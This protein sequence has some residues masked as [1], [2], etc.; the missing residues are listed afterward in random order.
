VRGHPDELRKVIVARYVE[1]DGFVADP[2]QVHGIPSLLVHGTISRGPADW[3]AVLQELTGAQVKEINSTAAATLLIPVGETVYALSYG[4]GYLLIDPQFIDP[5]FG[6]GFAVRAIDPDTIRQ[7]TRTAMLSQPR[8]ER[9]SVPAGQNIRWYGIEEYGEIVGRITGQLANVELTFNRGHKR[10][11]SVAGTDSLKVHLATNPADLLDDLQ[12]ISGVCDQESPAQELEFI[13]RL[14]A[15]KSKDPLI[16]QLNTLLD[17][18]LGGGADGELALAMPLACQNV[19]EEHQS[20]RVKIGKGR[21]ATEEDISLDTI[22]TLTRP[23]PTGHRAQALRDGYI[24]LCADA[25]G[26]VP[27]SSRVK[28][29]LWISADIALEAHRY[30]LHEG[31]WYE[32]GATHLET[33]R[34]QVE[35]LLSGAAS[36]SLPQWDPRFTREDEYNE[37]AVNHGFV[38]LDKKELHTAQHPHG[39][40]ACDLVGPN[41]EFIHVKAPTGSSELSH[42]FHQALTSYDALRYD[43]EARE[44]LSDRVRAARPG[45]TVPAQPKIVIFAVALKR[46]A[47]GKPATYRPLTVDTLFTF[48]QVSLV[49]TVR[50]FELAQVKVEVVDISP[51]A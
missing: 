39:I 3:S 35:S 38:V 31:K 42:L 25:E 48:S 24:Q 6:L 32:I 41:G 20:Y 33:I 19:E 13:A 28:G 36:V 2:V 8:Y 44:K 37:D 5:G 29:H 22:L 45:V 27:L 30:F 14:R 12:R 23:L 46:K 51:G 4:M 40:E 26:E 10:R 15:L 50:M 47:K 17:E 18:L 49:H 1:N 7:V 16:P 11:I 43:M 21:F 9:S 34:S